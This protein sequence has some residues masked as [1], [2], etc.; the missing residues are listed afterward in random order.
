MYTYSYIVTGFHNEK[1]MEY[2]VKESF[3]YYIYGL[4]EKNITEN[5]ETIEERKINIKVV[6]F[7]YPM[8]MIIM[9]SKVWFFVMI[10]TLKI[11]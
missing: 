2:N 9:I 3:T 8:K 4:C 6:I 1:L 5:K 7:L 10:R 11:E